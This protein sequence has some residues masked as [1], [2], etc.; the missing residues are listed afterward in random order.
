MQIVNVD[1]GDVLGVNVPIKVTKFGEFNFTVTAKGT[2]MSDAV[3]KPVQ[4]NVD[5]RKVSAAQAGTL[6]RTA[7]ASFNFA[8]NRIPNTEKLSVSVQPA[9]TGGFTLNFPDS[10][11]DDICF[12]SDAGTIHT[13]ALQLS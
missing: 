8:E 2:K 3:Q 6:A 9:S 11:Y 13:L 4:V 7:Q 1:A 10:Y 5:G 12:Y